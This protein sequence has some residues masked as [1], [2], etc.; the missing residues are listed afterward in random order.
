MC[1]FNG[2]RFLPAQLQ[3]IAQ[4]E[5]LPQELVVCD[6]RSSDGSV[7]VVEQFAAGAP[8]PVR[9]FRNDTNLGST[10]NFEKAIHLCQ[11][12]LIALCDQDDVWLPHKLSRLSEI[13]EQDESLG[14]VFSDAQLIDA[15]SRTLQKTL[16]QI[17]KFRFSRPQ[18]FTRTAAME[19]L[20]KHDVVT[21]A[22]LLIRKSARDLISPIPDLWVHDGWIAWMLILYSRLTFVREPLVQYRVHEG[23]QLGV[24]HLTL[25]Q[26]W[27]RSIGE[28]RGKLR[29]VQQQFE[30]LR[31]RWLDRPGEDFAH[32]VG[33]IEDKIAFL[34]RRS[35]LPDGFLRRG[36][37]ILASL[38]LYQH[39]ARGLSSAR[40]DLFLRPA[41][42]R[43]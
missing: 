34:R 10:R 18:D 31:E 1:T 2:A 27:R 42:F 38:H 11:G 7:E 30:A 5:R 37:S 41:G 33:I 3:S 6:D 15:Y 16:G 13:L 35:T 8:F 43:E 14:G 32:C 9:I 21:G 17:H 39:Y 25:L 24:G 26:R 22:T 19:L 28:D 23:Q 4:Q 36:Y 20:L 12:D 40:Q 29:N